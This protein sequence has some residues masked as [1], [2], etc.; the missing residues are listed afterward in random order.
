MSE[1]TSIQLWHRIGGRVVSTSRVVRSCPGR[2]DHLAGMLPSP[3]PWGTI[4]VRCRFLS[5]FPVLSFTSRFR[6]FGDDL[7]MTRVTLGEPNG[8]HTERTPANACERQAQPKGTISDACEPVRTPKPD[9]AV[10]GF[11]FRWA[12]WPSETHG[13]TCL[14]P[15]EVEEGPASGMRTA[16][17]RL[18]R[19]PS[20]SDSRST[21][22][23][24]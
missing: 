10:L 5:P 2:R 20:K 11:R 8:S 23:E 9:S 21:P 7:L 24:T 19:A 16:A 17:W 12:H 3:E 22:A 18:A 14:R 1:Q 4:A 15:S 13:W 6:P